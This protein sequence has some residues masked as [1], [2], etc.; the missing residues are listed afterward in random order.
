MR[1]N[2]YFTKSLLTYTQIM[3]EHKGCYACI[4]Q[5]AIL[6]CCHKACHDIE[7]C[8]MWAQ[9]TWPKINL[10]NEIGKCARLDFVT[11]L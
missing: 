9:V 1:F 7:T 11:F 6:R 10:T 5:D 2:G 8:E 4:K 3:C